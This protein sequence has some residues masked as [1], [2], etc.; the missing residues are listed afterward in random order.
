M[1]KR[2][3]DL[4]SAGYLLLVIV[5]VVVFF[6]TLATASTLILQGI[7][8][9]WYHNVSGTWTI[10]VIPVLGDSPAETQRQMNSIMRFL[11]ST[12]GIS[13]VQPLSP[14]QIT[15]L[16]EP[17][18]DSTELVSNISLPRLIE[19]VPQNGGLL[20]SETIFV[21]LSEIFPNV[22]L[23]DHKA[24]LTNIAYISCFLD[25]NLIALFSIMF[26]LVIVATFFVTKSKILM[27]RSIIE[28]LYLLGAQDDYIAIQFAHASL[29]QGLHGGLLGLSLALPVL[30]L[31]TGWLASHLEGDF[32]LTLTLQPAQM[33]MKLGI[34]PIGVAWL[35]WLAK[36]SARLTVYKVIARPI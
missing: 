10:Q 14:Q 13:V 8:E 25:L 31:I 19:V 29:M 34:I 21:E 30:L 32:W 24:W 26:V 20:D 16:L 23:D 28:I 18:L 4:P 12:P 3:S 35:A 5:T 9:R 27:Y 22:S 6:S 33:A 1:F 11:E 7:I 17:W 15:Q 36:V 2:H